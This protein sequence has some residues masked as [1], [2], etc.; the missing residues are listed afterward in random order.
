ME[1]YIPLDMPKLSDELDGDIFNDLYTNLS[2]SVKLFN[3][4]YQENTFYEN[5]ILAISYYINE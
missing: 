3:G 4:K 5:L 1:K 2:D